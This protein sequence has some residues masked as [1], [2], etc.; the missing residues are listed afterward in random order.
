MFDTLSG[1]SE[2]RI[3]VEV[4]AGL[5]TLE[6]LEIQIQKEFEVHFEIVKSE[7]WRSLP[8][9]TPPRMSVEDDTSPTGWYIH[10]CLQNRVVVQIQIEVKQLRNE[11]SIST[12][13]EKK[14]SKRI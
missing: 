14:D 13:L 6:G 8:H 10:L 3:L 2:E 4:L 7:V 11:F 5:E 9:L 1:S 12:G